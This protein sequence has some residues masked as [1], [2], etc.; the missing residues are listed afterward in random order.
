M[1]HTEGG[2][3]GISHPKGQIFHPKNPQNKKLILTQLC[4]LQ[5]DLSVKVSRT[6]SKFDST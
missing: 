6:S 1:F 5:S 4:N 2:E 3:G